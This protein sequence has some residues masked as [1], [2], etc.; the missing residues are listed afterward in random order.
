MLS[1]GGR[2]LAPV[3]NDRICAMANSV[4]RSSW[5]VPVLLTVIYLPIAVLEAARRPLWNDELFT[6][7][8]GALPTL[9]QV[10]GALL[11]GA[12][13]LPPFFFALTRLAASPGMS[14]LT[15]RLPAILG[16]WVLMLCL[17]QFVSRSCGRLLGGTAALLPCL[18]GAFYYASEARPYGLVLGFTGLALLAWQRAG[19]G[20]TVPWSLLLWTALACAYSCHYYAVFIAVP[21]AAGELARFV[22]TRRIDIPVWLAIVLSPAVLVLYL[23]LLRAAHSFS[24]HFWARPEIAELKHTLLDLTNPA[25]AVLFG[26]A[27]LLCI[28]LSRITRTAVSSPGTVSMPFAEIVVAVAFALLP[29]YVLL[30][31]KALGGGYTERYVITGIIGFALLICFGLQWLV[32]NLR[33]LQLAALVLSGMVFVSHQLLHY[34]DSIETQRSGQLATYRFLERNSGDQ[35]IIIGDPHL[36]FELSH[37]FHG[38]KLE[39]IY[40]ADPQLALHYTGTDSVERSLMAM[41]RFAP[42]KVVPWEDLSRTGRSYLIYGAPWAYDWLVRLISS[43]R[44]RTQVV[45]RD[46]AFNYLFRISGSESALS[47]TQ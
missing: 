3:L 43:G 46:D 24:V 34:R 44:Y 39:M 5:I 8:I 4:E 20:R 38:R 6:W 17:Y 10:W 25:R 45:A 13:Q 2:G 9:K 40:A 33:A 19:A 1:R 7:Y 11:T 12:E 28:S 35:P 22:K 15:I 36:F 47:S 29:F 16:F 32:P 37:A 31:A 18:S 30:A 26:I 42:L 14:E 27:V 21:I 41:A 23:P